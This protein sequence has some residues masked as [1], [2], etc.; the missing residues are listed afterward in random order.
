MFLK[1]KESAA[2]MNNDSIKDLQAQLDLQGNALEQAK[3]QLL[4]LAS[5]RGL[6][7][8]TAA[9]I[10]KASLFKTNS[11]YSP[12]LLSAIRMSASLFGLD[13]LQNTAEYPHPH[14]SSLWADHPNL[15][16]TGYC[17]NLAFVLSGYVAGDS[18]LFKLSRES[19]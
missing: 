17:S 7:F 19:F 16:A 5:D 12:G 18:Y 6:R 15:Q 10:I 2:S 4:M 1:K 3:S 9:R 13:S 8:I 14:K 11:L